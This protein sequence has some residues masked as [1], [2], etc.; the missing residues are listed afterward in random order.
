MLYEKFNVSWKRSLAKRTH[1]GRIH[2][3]VLNSQSTLRLILFHMAHSVTNTEF[4]LFTSVFL[5]FYGNISSIASSN[6]VISPTKYDVAPFGRL[7]SVFFGVSSH[8]SSK[9]RDFYSLSFFTTLIETIFLVI[10][11]WNFLEFFS[12]TLKIS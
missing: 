10:S 8:C 3:Y 6:S 2:Y 11:S 9:I 12:K 5:S 4:S 1:F 7:H